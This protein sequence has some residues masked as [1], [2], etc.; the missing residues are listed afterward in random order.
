MRTLAL[1]VLLSSSTASADYWYGD[2]PMSFRRPDMMSLSSGLLDRMQFAYARLGITSEIGSHDDASTATS[3]LHLQFATP[4]ECIFGT[5]FTLPLAFALVDPPRVAAAGMTPPPPSSLGFG[6]ADVG[7][8]LGKSRSHANALWRIGALLPTA[9]TSGPHTISA[10]AGDMVLELPRSAGARFSA[11]HALGLWR[12]SST[13]YGGLRIDTG[14]DLA[15]ELDRDE[16]PMHVVPHAGIGAMFVFQRRTVSID[17][18]LA[19]DPRDRG[20]LNVRWST[21]LTTRF[22]PTS[23]LGSW[24]QPGITI[25]MVRTPD[26]WGATLAIDLAA[27]KYRDQPRE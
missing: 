20:E 5:Y 24:M 15:Y 6:T 13:S 22:A 14:L 16:N 3:T 1:I 25:A 18:V 27:S 12:P 21:G 8:Y 26:G 23:G 19:M 17:S 9:P 7:V 10:R 11:S 4:S 2:D